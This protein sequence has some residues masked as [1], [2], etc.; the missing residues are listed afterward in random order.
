MQALGHARREGAQDIHTHARTHARDNTAHM[1][2]TQPGMQRCA[3]PVG[4]AALPGGRDHLHA[5]RFAPKA[6]LQGH[7]HMV[8]PHNAAQ[9]KS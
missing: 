3:R 8:L 5:F 2:V 1:L 4:W 7:I 6:A 9:V